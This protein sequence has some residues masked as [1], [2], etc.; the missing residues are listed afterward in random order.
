ME[1]VI[2]LVSSADVCRPHSTSTAIR[3]VIEEVVMICD[4]VILAAGLGTRM[5]SDTPKV[6]HTLGERPILTWVVDSCREATQN[7]PIVVV[8]PDADEIRN[9][10]VQWH[11]SNNVSMIWFHR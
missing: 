11:H 8:G 2:F 10:M 9:Q 3:P 1:E 4:A 5:K 7:A 6:L